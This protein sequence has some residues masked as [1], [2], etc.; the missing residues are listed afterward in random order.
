ME[1]RTWSSASKAQ[2]FRRKVAFSPDGRTLATASNDGTIKLLQTATLSELITLRAPTSVANA[3]FS[4]DG[5]NLVA[6]CA[7]G[8]IMRWRAEVDTER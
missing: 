1:A 2:A 5:R 6:A 8:T 4:P 3:A 7:D